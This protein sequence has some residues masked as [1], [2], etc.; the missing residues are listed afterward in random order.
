MPQIMDVVVKVLLIWKS[1]KEMDG[2]SISDG[3]I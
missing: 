2:V 1:E 3:M